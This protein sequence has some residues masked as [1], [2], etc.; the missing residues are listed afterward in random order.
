MH[1][2]WGYANL[3]AL[4]CLV[5]LFGCLYVQTTTREKEMLLYIM[6]AA[7]ISG[8][9]YMFQ[10]GAKSKEAAT[11][12]L[13]SAYLGRGLL[14]FL[15]FRFYAK[16]YRLKVPKKIYRILIVAH[17]VIY[18]CIVSSNYTG[19][20]YADI[21]MGIRNGYRHLIL[22]P[23][24]VWYVYYALM[25][26][27]YVVIMW[28]SV[29]CYRKTKIKQK[30]RLAMFS[31]I[32]VSLPMI[33]FF[34]Y[35]N[36]ILYPYNPMELGV[37]LGVILVVAESLRLHI[38]DTVVVG[39]EAAIEKMHDMVIILNAD[40]QVTYCNQAVSRLLEQSEAAQQMLARGIDFS[41]LIVENEKVTKTEIELD[42]RIYE[43]EMTKLESGRRLNGYVLNTR[44]V[45]E[46]RRYAR[47]LEAMVRQ[48]TYQLEALQEE[49]MISFAEMIERR[50]GLTGEHV[51]RTKEYVRMIANALVERGELE[52]SEAD[53]MAKV[54]PL[55]DIGKIAVPDAILN[56]PGKLT[57]EEF[58]IIKT[59][60]TVGG[61]M[62]ARI[63][64]RQD[65][66]GYMQ[67][68][69]EM[70]LYHH[71]KW[72]GTGYPQQLSGEQIPLEARIM[73]VAD[74]FDALVSKRCYK[75]AISY[76]KAFVIL[77]EGAGKHFDARLVDI[78][79]SLK[80]QVIAVA[81]SEGRDAAV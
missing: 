4:I 7:F 69:Y 43:C 62:L 74:V 47:H 48:K 20:F 49:M 6:L 17:T 61:E 24:V 40:C 54:A 60:T 30:K 13:Y 25:L 39:K 34:L 22:T 38:F 80:E 64:D 10:L 81:E 21:T 76:D 28:M 15:T 33:G 31:M 79:L 58:E 27:Y 70:A 19:L 35:L 75:E 26:F 63:R 50:D 32:G 78:F 52:Q 41:N 8:L 11:L 68:A 5:I 9:G 71:E 3:A 55:H 16:Y 12:S 1:N 14:G 44:D 65:M 23:G 77:K 72:D 29:R 66:D 2:F 67:T 36:K 37:A 18:L 46:Q 57:P 45:T 53:R 42:R 51:N 59:H 73:A 56:K